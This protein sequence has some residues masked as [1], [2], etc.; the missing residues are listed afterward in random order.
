M[1]GTNKPKYRRVLLKISGESLC[2]ERGFGLDP[3][4]MRWIAK[5]LKAAVGAG[6]QMAVVVGGG[7]FLRGAVA[8]KMASIDE[9]TAHH[10]G[11]LATVMNGLALQEVLEDVGVETR[12]MS[13]LEVARVCEPYD[14]RRCIGHLKA[15]RLVILAGGTGRPFVT[16]DT[17]AA[18]GA[19]EIGA[20]V[21][22]KATKVDGVYSDDPVKNPKAKRY[23]RLTY[24]EVIRDRLGVMDLSAFDLCREQGLPIIV[25]DFG[26]AGNVTKV[27]SGGTVGTVVSSGNAVGS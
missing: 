20:E 3:D 22:L 12:V 4:A 23:T 10:M 18:I 24:D 17:A 14:R 25:F 11:M 6:A 27:V 26:K 21:L 9:A 8:S 7:N 15:G 19:L 2:G 1:A 16:T 5:E 13:A